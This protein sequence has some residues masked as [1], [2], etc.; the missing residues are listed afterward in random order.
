MS[1]CLGF[2][3]WNGSDITFLGA[4]LLL[5]RWARACPCLPVV[6]GK[7]CVPTLNLSPVSPRP[8]HDAVENDHL[9]IV[10]LLLSYGAD[11]TL[12]TYSGRTIMKMT[13]SELMEKFLTG[14][15]EFP[16][17]SYSN[18]QMMTS[19]PS[20][21]SPGPPLFTLSLLTGKSSVKLVCERTGP[22]F[23]EEMNALFWPVRAGR[24]P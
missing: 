24:D 14:T 19:H 5:G 16:K 4:T 18:I 11:P 3:S 12:A 22:E 15:T 1:H 10:R 20:T 7:H 8:L 23:K 6:R 17:W 2:P 21:H 13:H 9:E